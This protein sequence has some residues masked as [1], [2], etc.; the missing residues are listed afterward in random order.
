MFVEELNIVQSSVSAVTVILNIKYLSL[1]L[2]FIF[3]SIG[4][5]SGHVPHPPCLA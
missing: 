5:E 2:E 3:F 1:S 4:I